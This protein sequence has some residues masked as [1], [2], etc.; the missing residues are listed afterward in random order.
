MGMMV[1]SLLRVMQD[2]YPKLWELW[3]MPYYG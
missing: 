1:Y 2:L 3:Y